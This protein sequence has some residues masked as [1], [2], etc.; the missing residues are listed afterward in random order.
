MVDGIAFSSNYLTR[1]PGGRPPSLLGGGG[2]I[3]P[4]VTQAVRAFVV[5]KGALLASA[6]S[7]PLPLILAI[8][9]LSASLHATSR[10]LLLLTL[11]PMLPS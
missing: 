4:W 11:I 10:P 9:A 1:L 5:V 2:L 7:N 8:H 3:P 6:A